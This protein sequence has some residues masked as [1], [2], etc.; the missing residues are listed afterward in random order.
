MHT[1]L[2]KIAL[3]HNTNKLIKNLKRNFLSEL[4]L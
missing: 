4:S 1:T 3:K 2:L